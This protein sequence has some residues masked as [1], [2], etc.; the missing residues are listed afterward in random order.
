MGL[1]IVFL[2]FAVIDPLGYAI[3]RKNGLPKATGWKMVIPFCWVF[4]K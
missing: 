4:A 3:A 1:F 2:L